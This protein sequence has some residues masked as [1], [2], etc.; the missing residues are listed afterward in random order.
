MKIALLALAS[1]ASALN[2]SQYKMSVPACSSANYGACGK[3]S[4]TVAPMKLQADMD[5]H[6]KDY[7]VPNFGMDRDIVDSHASLKQ[8][9]KLLDHKLYK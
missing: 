1:V 7:F 9:E 3:T 4:E 8:S 2:M 5:K 6:K